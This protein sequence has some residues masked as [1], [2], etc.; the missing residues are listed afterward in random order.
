M[1]TQNLLKDK[2]YYLLSGF[3]ITRLI[4][5]FS[6]R[7][8][9]NMSLC[10]GNTESSLKN[11][12]DFLNSL[13]ISYQDLV[14]ARQVHGSRIRY[15]KESDR[16]K[17]ALNYNDSLVDTDAL[18]TDQRNLPLAVFSAD[19]LSIFLYAPKIPAIGL[20]HA[21]WRSTKE[22]IVIKT[23]QIMQKEFNMHIEDI[24]VGFGP[25]IRSCCYEVEKKFKDFFSDDLIKRNNHCYLDLVRINKKQ[26]LDLG[27]KEHNISD[28]QICTS[29]QNSDF[30]SFR[31]EG[32]SCGRIMS[33]IMLK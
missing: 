16:G 17:G 24:S 30:F 6:S 31:K 27:V 23:L 10:Y 20:V 25:A 33:V 9:G 7:H 18:V 12:K 19:C 28:A 8:L 29:C 11:R 3:P 14:C 2:E 21:G 15:V 1:T 4:C 22:K 32:N 26:V 13:G 5:A